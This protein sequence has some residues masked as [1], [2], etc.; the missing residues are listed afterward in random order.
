MKRN[1]W[2]GIG[3]F[4]WFVYFVDGG[5]FCVKSK[6]SIELKAFL[7]TPLLVRIK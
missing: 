1:H 5:F 6:W 2:Q 4:G 7:K 3:N